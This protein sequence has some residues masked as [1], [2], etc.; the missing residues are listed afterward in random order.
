MEV[1]VQD[2]VIVEN[3]K[4]TLE[5]VKATFRKWLYLKDETVIDVVLGCVV[6]NRSQSD[7]VWVFIVAP[8]GGTKTEVLR[9]LKTSETYHLSTLTR[10]SLISGF[11]I[12]RKD[13]SR[14]DPSLLPLLD[15]KVLIIKDFTT[16][17]S[18]DKH[19]REEILATLRDAYDG[20][21]RKTFGSETMTRS[22]K[23]KFGF[24][25]GVTPEIDRIYS[26]SQS[27]G[28][29][30]IKYR[31]HIEDRENI[32]RKASQNLGKEKDMRMEL[33]GVTAR[34][35]RTLEMS[36]VAIPDE[37][38]TK[39][40][41]LALLIA[42]LRT[43]VSRDSYNRRNVQFMPETEVG[44]RLVK[45]LKGLAQGLA[46]VRGKKEITE[47]EYE[48]ITKIAK[49]TLPSKRLS[50]LQA[51]ITLKGYERTSA[52][53]QEIKLHVNTVREML[54]DFWLLEVVDRGGEENA[55]YTWHLKDNIK[56]LI[57]VT[58]L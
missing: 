24:L 19:A 14:I 39:F 31:T 52:I 20:E 41:N 9:S 32:I 40:I 15:G 34:F 3:E 33:M 26:V 21:A 4:V 35:L 57:C 1:A 29:R 8:P 45:Q 22:Y 43:S 27:L 11:M 18:M 58:G 51:L 53:A 30:F 46:L 28:E 13:G 25:A 50:L 6:A 54:E 44:T 47:A 55:G 17:I 37:L 38:D 23:S 48:L 42:Q 12:K 49:D 7:P 16:V 5:E 56:E 10:H 36:N 2:K